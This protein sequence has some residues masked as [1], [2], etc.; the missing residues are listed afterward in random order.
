LWD[1]AFTNQPPVSCDSV[2]ILISYNSGVTYSTL[3][4]SAPNFGFYAI[5]APNLTTSISTCRIRIE[6]KNNI[7][8]DISNNN[9]QISIDPYVGLEELGAVNPVAL[10]VWPNP[11]N[12]K[13]NVT[14]TG[15]DPNLSTELKVT[16]ISG[17]T[18]LV[19]SISN[20]AWLR[21]TIDVSGLESGLYFIS[22]SNSGRQ[23]VQ[24]ILKD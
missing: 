6:G 12:S 4:G 5:T 9:F 2:R 20:A 23:T 17:R 15:L 3:V 16:D 1:P 7:F 8:Y 18:V 19:K 24:R 10:S 13:M 21:E 14:A 22:V 11:S